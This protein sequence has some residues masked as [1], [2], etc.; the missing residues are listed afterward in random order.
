METIVAAAIGGATAILAAGLSAAFTARHMMAVTREQIDA[1]RIAE[2][3]RV[4]RQMR[5]TRV[6][7]MRTLLQELREA[8]AYAL[9]T[10]QVG[11]AVDSDATTELIRKTI[12]MGGEPVSDEAV[13]DVRKRLRELTEEAE[14]IDDAPALR[15]LRLMNRLTT[16]ATVSGPIREALRELDAA[17]SRP[18]VEAGK[19]DFSGQ[20]LAILL[21]HCDEIEQRIDAHVVNG[22]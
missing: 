15:I 12:Q 2:E 1:D 18:M 20:S 10:L 8:T 22:A 19:T 14:G 7:S 3:T 4:R 11:A 21:V 9:K 16:E 5:E 13:E 17:W 6:N